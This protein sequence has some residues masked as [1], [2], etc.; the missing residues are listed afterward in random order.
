MLYKDD[1]EK[2]Q[3]RMKAWWAGEIIDRPVIQVVAPRKGSQTNAPWDM[4]SLVHN[5]T[6]PERVV[7]EFGNYCQLTYF[8]GEFL[9]NLWVNLGPGIIAAY[10]GAEPKIAED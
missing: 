10:I 9:P 8:G 2:A 5:L 3:E 1:W 4:E 7:E 6:N